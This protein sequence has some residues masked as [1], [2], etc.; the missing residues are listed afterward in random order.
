MKCSICNDEG[1]YCVKSKNPAEIIKSCEPC[2][3]KRKQSFDKYAASI[4]KRRM[5]SSASNFL[6]EESKI[7]FQMDYPSVKEF[8][9]ANGSGGLR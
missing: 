5:Y 2:K 6:E 8:M 1:W 4:A 3:A 9:K 7:Q